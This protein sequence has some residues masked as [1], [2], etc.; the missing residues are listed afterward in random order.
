M[1]A[2]ESDFGLQLVTFSDDTA[3]TT[4][5]KTLYPPR[6]SGDAREFAGAINREGWSTTSEMLSL[7][8]EISLDNGASWSAV[9]GV[10]GSGGVTSAPNGE[11]GK[12]TTCTARAITGALYRLVAQSASGSIQRLL[13]FQEILQ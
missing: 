13:N 3:T 9:C 5:P 12:E 10:T 11:L 4:I 6:M 2:H 8:V 7:G 1:G